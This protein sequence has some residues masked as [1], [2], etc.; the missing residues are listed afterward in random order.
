MPSI[1]IESLFVYPLKSAAG[2]QVQQ[3]TLKQTG[4]EQDRKWMLVNQHGR[5]LT[6]RQHPKLA[7]IQAELQNGQL[8]LS[9]PAGDQVTLNKQQLE[10]EIEVSLWSDTVL[11]RRIGGA[12]HRQLINL[13]KPFVETDTAGV[14]LVYFDQDKIRTPAKPER[15]GLS[16]RHFADAA[17]YLVCNQASLE[18]LNSKLKHGGENDVDMR[19]FRPNIVVS[20]LPAFAE[21]QYK[22]M[23]L[24]NGA[25]LELVDH[26]ERCVMITVDP[27][28]GIKHKNQVPFKQLASLNAMPDKKHAPAFGVN[29]RLA[30]GCDNLVIQQGDILELQ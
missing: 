29:L 20:G 27:D 5:A 13:L 3:A 1:R 10:D 24:K 22:K 26:C 17:P 7:L 4:F 6:Q 11:A 16:A 8:I 23:T 18:Q 2:K 30:D 28:S 12:S 21:H 15:F 19:H 25:V 14:E 9:F